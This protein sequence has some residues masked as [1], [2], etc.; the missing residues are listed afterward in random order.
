VRAGVKKL[1]AAS[2]SG[3]VKEHTSFLSF[4]FLSLIVEKIW[5]FYIY[6]YNLIIILFYFPNVKILKK[7]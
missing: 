7:L 1:S 5:I 3:G 2:S 6:Y 4:P